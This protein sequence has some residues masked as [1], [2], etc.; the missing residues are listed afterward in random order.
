MVGLPAAANRDPKVFTD[1]GRF[2]IERPNSRDHLSFA[3]GVH[4]CLGAGLARM[5][6]EIALRGLFR[7]YPRLQQVGRADYC[8]SRVIRG[9][10]R[11]MVRTQ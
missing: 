10:R 2:D 3:A 9:P 8:P 5:E 11:L 7:R 1:P 4:Y 6:G